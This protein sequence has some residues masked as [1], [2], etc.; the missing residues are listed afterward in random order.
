L[1]AA[2]GSCWVGKGRDL[3]R[4]FLFRHDPP[5][6]LFELMNRTANVIRKGG[7]GKFRDGMSCTCIRT[8]RVR[9]V[10]ATGLGMLADVTLVVVGIQFARCFFAESGTR[11]D[12]DA[13]S[14]L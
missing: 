9:A 10:I 2:D 1:G 7:Q 14:D 8:R 13:C 5:R 11:F 3:S 6:L 4:P 12:L